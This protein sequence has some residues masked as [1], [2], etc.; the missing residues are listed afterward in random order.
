MCKPPQS[1]TKST[2]IRDKS[3]TTHGC[4]GLAYRVWGFMPY[5]LTAVQDH[6]HKHCQPC[7]VASAA[8]ST[9]VYMLMWPCDKQGSTPAQLR[10]C[11]CI[12]AVLARCVPAPCHVAKPPKHITAGSTAPMTPPPPPSKYPCSFGLQPQSGCANT[13]AQL[14]AHARAWQ[15]VLQQRAH[16]AAGCAPVP[17]P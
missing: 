7:C 16:Q 2:Q 12:Y 10:L 14:T 13:A 3:R 17:P 6:A 5:T 1:P 15:P 4:K 9:V 8:L 11:K